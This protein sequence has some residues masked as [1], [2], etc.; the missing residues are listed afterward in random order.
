DGTRGRVFNLSDAGV[1]QQEYIDKFLRKT[2]YQTIRIAYIPYWLARLAAATFRG[3]RL[4]SQRIPTVDKR[5]LASLYR[6]VEVNTE[7]IKLTAGWQPRKNLLETLVAEAQRSKITA[8]HAP[9]E[10]SKMAI[11][12][13]G[14]S[15]RPMCQSN[16][17][18]NR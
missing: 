3:L 9:T 4:L 12:P 5:R 11:S 13:Q 6:N 8:D 7:S 2:G 1:A 17:K 16:A 15:R 14:L 10:L 18:D